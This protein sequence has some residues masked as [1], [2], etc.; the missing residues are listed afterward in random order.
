MQ[1]LTHVHIWGIT[2]LYTSTANIVL[3]RNFIH[4]I[5]FVRSYFADY[6]SEPKMNNFTLSWTEIW[7]KKLKQKNAQYWILY[8]R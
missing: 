5:T 3:L 7:L 1:Y 2:Q 6:P 4:L 8:G